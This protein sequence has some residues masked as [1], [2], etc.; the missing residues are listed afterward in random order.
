MNLHRMLKEIIAHIDARFDALE[1]KLIKQAK[2]KKEV[3]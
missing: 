1:A 2:P 3:K